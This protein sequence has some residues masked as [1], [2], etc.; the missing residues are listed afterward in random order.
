MRL[1]HMT[2]VEVEKAIEDELAIILP[3]GAITQYGPHLPL[4]TNSIISHQLALRAAEQVNVVVAPPHWYGYAYPTKDLVGN[5][6]IPP[7]TLAD[8]VYDI[9]KSLAKEGFS[10]FLLLYGQ[11]PN[12]TSLNYASQRLSL[13][14][15]I[16]RIA[17]AAWWQLGKKTM[18]ERFGDDPGYH[19]MA[20]ETALM[21][22]LQPE[23][24]REGQIVDEMPKV[25]L[26]YDYYPRPTASLTPSGVRGKP[27]LAT[28]EN[29]EAL[30]NEIVANLVDMLGHDLLFESKWELLT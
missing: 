24:V 16:T 27:S 30:A 2:W 4:G 13:D 17:V 26:G 25:S 11:L 19:A 29:G 7:A 8:Y 28:R 5:V 22:A 14:Y 23:L 1:E 3:S 20:S 10:K 15:P 6:T 9:L 18:K 21:M 12:I